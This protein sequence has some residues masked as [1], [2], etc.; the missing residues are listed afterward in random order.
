M[1]SNN[2]TNT[3]DSHAV[4]NAVSRT[5]DNASGSAHRAI[6]RASDAARPAV[7]QLSS[8]AHKT[9]ERVAGAANSAAQSIDA[10][11]DQLKHAGARF[12]DTCRNQLN[13]KPIATIGIAIG[14]GFLL[15]WLMRSR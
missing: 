13:D 6:D 12:A 1:S 5:V 8:G 4:G 7:D 10:G 3:P 11:S 9:V 14:A 15:S 2:S